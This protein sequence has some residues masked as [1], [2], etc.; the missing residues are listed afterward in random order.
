VVVGNPV[1]VRVS[2]R[3]QGG[4]IWALEVAM[5]LRRLTLL[6]TLFLPFLETLLVGRNLINIMIKSLGVQEDPEM[7]RRDV[8][9]MAGMF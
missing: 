4:G 6:T 7:K 8:I 1:G 5:A 2:L 3:P 9:A